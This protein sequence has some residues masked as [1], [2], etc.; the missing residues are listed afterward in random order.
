MKYLHFFLITLSLLAIVSC[1][2]KVR[3]DKANDTDI[4]PAKLSRVTELSKRILSAQR[5]GGYYPLTA[6]EATPDMIKGLT[7]EVQKSAYQKVSS[8]F[9]DYQDIEFD[10]MMKPT[11]GQLFEL[12]R[13]R[14]QFAPG[15]EV[16]VRAVVDAKGKLAG[17]FIK[18]WNDNP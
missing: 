12:Y 6:E 4:D 10:H 2:S 11:D 3:F 17:F 18:P 15:A 9:G 8:A 14:G 5:N 7:E 1:E 13:Y 16:E